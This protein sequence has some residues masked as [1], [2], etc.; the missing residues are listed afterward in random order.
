MAEDMH[1]STPTIH[2][3]QFSVYIPN[4]KIGKCRLNLSL[5]KIRLI[6]D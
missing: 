1:Q 6:K 2:G 5:L 3:E 4:K